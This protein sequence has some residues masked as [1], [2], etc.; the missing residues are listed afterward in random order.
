ML[1]LFPS[2]VSLANLPTPYRALVS[3]SGTQ[4]WI[5][6]D[7]QSGSI[8]SGN[9]VRKLEYLLAEAKS[10][11]AAR[12]ITCG[13]LQSNHCRATA[14]ACARLNLKCSLILRD[15]RGLK[16][17]AEKLDPVGNV[18]LD[19]LAGA[20]IHIIPAAEYHRRLDTIFG[21]ISSRYEALGES[22][23]CIPTGGSNGL[24]VWGYVQCCQELLSD[25]EQCSQIPSVIV[26]AAGSGGT[27]A[28]LALGCALL[29]IP[30][31]ILGFAV[32]DD[33]Q[34]F[35]DKVEA[36][37]RECLQAS[38]LS[39]AQIDDLLS[40]LNYDV[41]DRYIGPGYARPYPEMIQC[42]DWAAKN[43]G[44]IFDPVYT[45]KAFYGCLEEIKAGR[46]SD[47]HITFVHT[48]GVFGLQAYANEFGNNSL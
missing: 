19:Q 33:R 25:F 23:Y 7:D 36:D 26:C 6:S 43:L 30:A 37:I 28:G 35:L 11:G 39:A 34:Y 42:I 20:D 2:K 4:V 14:L 16:V 9:K 8:L 3:V 22:V 45:G 31:R 13:G 40:R 21:E 18:L 47:E 27:L 1:S 38:E 32:C 15:N 24:G 17:S 5:K 44:E 46:L 29:K 41:I 10:K 12:V 48:G